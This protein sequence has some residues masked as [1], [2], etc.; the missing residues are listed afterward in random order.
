MPTDCLSLISYFVFG[1][2][3]IVFTITLIKEV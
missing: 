1:V 3:V 2:L